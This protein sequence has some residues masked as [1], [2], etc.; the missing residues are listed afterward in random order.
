MLEALATIDVMPFFGRI[1]ENQFSD[2]LSS[3]LYSSFNRI[4]CKQSMCCHHKP[5]IVEFIEKQLMNTTTNRTS[6][7]WN[8]NRNPFTMK[9]KSFIIYCKLLM[10]YAHNEFSILRII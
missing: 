2:P 1:L 4:L 10:C 6:N 9:I 8:L 3:R 7:R 5:V